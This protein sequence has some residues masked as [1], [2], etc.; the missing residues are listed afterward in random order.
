MESLVGLYSTLTTIANRILQA[1]QPMA[2]DSG[3]RFPLRARSCGGTLWGGICQSWFR[4]RGN[5][6]II[7][8]EQSRSESS[9]LGA[10]F[11]DLC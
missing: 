1:A 11:W 5:C 7:G 4:L 6:S 9:C 10:C 8:S 3:S 2:A